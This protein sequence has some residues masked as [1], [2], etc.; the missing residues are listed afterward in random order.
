MNG[1]VRQHLAVGRGQRLRIAY[2]ADQVTGDVATMVLVPVARQMIVVARL[3]HGRWRVIRVG[4]G[5]NGSVQPAGAD[6]RYQ[7][8]REENCAG[9]VHRARI[10]RPSA[11]S[12]VG[13]NIRNYLAPDRC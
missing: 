11:Q 3:M 1:L 12:T 4:C 7:Q 13:G 6:R 8:P 10:I 5:R 2:R 9:A